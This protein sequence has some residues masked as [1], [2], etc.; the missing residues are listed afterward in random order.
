MSVRSAVA[1]QQGADDE[2]LAKADDY[3]GSDLTDVQKAALRLADTYLNSP[4]RMPD[5]VRSSAV[6][7]LSLAQAVELAVQLMGFSNDKVMVALGFDLDRVDR[8]IM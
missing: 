8:I 1:L 7:H 3:E 4:A 5:P 6:A 2:L